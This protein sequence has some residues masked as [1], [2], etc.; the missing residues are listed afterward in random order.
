M[1]PK[2]AEVFT[3]KVEAAND[4]GASI[5]AV[6]ILLKLFTRKSL[7]SIWGVVNILQIIVFFNL[8]KAP[9]ASHSR[10]FL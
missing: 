7:Q 1:N 2:F 3:E 4:A 5:V 8:I 10:L 6:N 9:I